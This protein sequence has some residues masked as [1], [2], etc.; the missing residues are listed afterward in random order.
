MNISNKKKKTKPLKRTRLQA[1]TLS[2]KQKGTSKSKTIQKG[3]QVPKWFKS[4]PTGSHG[5]TPAQKKYW[6][7]VS[8]Y[9]RERDWKKYGYCVS[10]KTKILDWKTGDAAHFKRYSVCN[11][12]FKFHPDN[13]ALSC[14]NCNRNDDG[15][16]GHAFGEE[17]IKRYGKRHLLWI[18]ETNLSFKGQKM[19]TWQIVEKVEKLRP[20]LIK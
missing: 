11:S 6:K 7:V 9:V 3:Y 15:V 1:K 10:C 19:K 18:E 5:N 12:Y 13:I 4:L 16:V 8:D 20:D 14:K 17:L 2:N